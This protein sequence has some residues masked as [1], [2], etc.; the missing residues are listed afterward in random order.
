M[1]RKPMPCR[2]LIDPPAK[3]SW[4]MA[5]DEVLLEEVTSSGEPILRFYQWSRPTLSLGYFQRAEDHALH[6]ASAQADL[7][8]R[9]SGGGAILH[10]QELT[11]S[12][13]L[14]ETHALA[15]DTQKLYDV[16]HQTLVDLLRNV[17][18][19]KH[20]PWQ[21]ELCQP[22]QPATSR[23]EPFLCFQRRT[24]GDIL[25]RPSESSTIAANHKVVGSAQRRRRGTVLQHGSILLGTSDFAP[26]ISGISDLAQ[27]DVSATTLRKL[28][29]K[30]IAAVLQL[31]LQPATMTEK[32]CDR[33]NLLMK[34]KYD[35]DTWTLRR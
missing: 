29:S 27:F 2:L 21:P 9:L 19:D 20:N 12:L 13:I 25:L 18:N 6:A 4:N 34:T 22:Q 32:L 1:S 5:V 15:G 31:T 23:D 14:P 7:V 3:G 8:R 16:V 30:K 35:S 26:E 11:Y 17:L 28:F 10:D 24:A 33:A